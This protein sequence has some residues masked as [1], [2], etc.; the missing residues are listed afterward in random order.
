MTL[1]H[2]LL[3]YNQ[4]TNYI[5]CV[6]SR[7]TTT[8]TTKKIWQTLK[9]Q[10]PTITNEWLWFPENSAGT[11]KRAPRLHNQPPVLPPSLSP[12]GAVGP[13]GGRSTQ[14]GGPLPLGS[15]PQPPASGTP[16]P[17]SRPGRGFLTKRSSAP[18]HAERCRWLTTPWDRFRNRHWPQCSLQFHTSMR[19]GSFNADSYR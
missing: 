14:T 13:A 3:S 1:I 12:L 5:I 15:G 4:R 8:T 10:R 18:T 16:Q 19:I 11:H 17:L 2:T 9:P 7:A 6:R